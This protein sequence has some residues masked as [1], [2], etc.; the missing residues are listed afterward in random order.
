MWPIVFFVFSLK[1]RL[2]RRSLLDQKR[3]EIESKAVDIMSAL[4]A[5]GD[6]D[7]EEKMG[8]H[9]GAVNS[10]RNSRQSSGASSISDA[11]FAD[12]S[13]NESGSDD[14][15]MVGE[16]DAEGNFV[17]MLPGE[18]E[19]LIEDEEGMTFKNIHAAAWMPKIADESGEVLS[20]KRVRCFS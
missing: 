15:A 13:L 8:R 18:E 9:A 7:G 1:M 5:A 17:G 20:T 12:G 2:Y 16:V 6:N 14:D 4:A 11:S 3:E 19:H 10:K